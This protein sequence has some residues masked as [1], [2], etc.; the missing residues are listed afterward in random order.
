MEK[1]TQDDLVVNASSD[2]TSAL[3]RTYQLMQN[4]LSRS[5][6]AT[7]TLGTLFR[8]RCCDGYL[9]TLLLSRTIYGCSIVPIG[10]IH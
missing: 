8:R 7:Q 9:L 6:F 3:R 1:L 4:E 2:V 5:Q 10:I